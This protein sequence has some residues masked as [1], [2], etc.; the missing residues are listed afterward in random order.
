VGCR[1]GRKAL[2]KQPL[3]GDRRMTSETTR[4][5]YEPTDRQTG[6]RSQFPPQFHSSAAKAA[7]ATEGGEFLSA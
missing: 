1:G 2:I 5:T 3:C 6:Q 4:L 7:A